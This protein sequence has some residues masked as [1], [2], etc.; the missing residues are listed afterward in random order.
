MS[1]EPGPREPHT[2]LLIE[3]DPDHATLIRRYLN[4]NEDGPLH[5]EWVN[6]LQKGLARLGQGGVE[7]VLL[8]LGLP[9]TTPQGALQDTL[10]RASHVPV[11]V[12]TARNSWD[13]TVDA[14]A[15]KL[16]AQD[17]LVKSQLNSEML[18]RSI[19][20]AVERK[21][22]EEQ[23]RRLNETL[24][25]RIA[26]RSAMAE[27]RANQLRAL[28]S[29]LILTEQRQRRRIAAELHDY[30]AQLL[31]VCRMKLTLLQDMVDEGQPAAALAD[32]Q[33]MVENS[34]RY[35]RTLV[36]E[37]SP[38]V[39]YEAGLDAALQWLAGQMEKN[40]LKVTFT[41][42]GELDRLPEDH[43]VLLFQSVRELLFNVIKHARVSDAEL[44]M[45]VLPSHELELEVRD[46]GVGCDL[47]AAKQDT[48]TPRFGI[49]SI[50]ERLAAIGGQFEFT[51]V[52]GE[53]TC[54]RITIPIAPAEP[55][56]PAPAGAANRA[57]GTAKSSS[58]TS[59]SVIRVLLADDHALV[60]QGLSS[61]LADYGDVQVI[62]E[63][64]NGEEAVEMA[65]LLQ[66]D[67]V[68]MDINMPK[69]NGIEATRRIK[70][71]M[72]EITVLALSVLDDKEMAAQ[73]RRAGAEAYLTKDGAADELYETIRRLH[74]TKS[75][76][77]KASYART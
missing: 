64:G 3:D 55:A 13:G 50:Q 14:D 10:A 62:G 21:R 8:D 17:Y 32:A 72:P 44:V 77:S 51:S 48:Q 63:A 73:M 42:N 69:V 70:S 56:E 22:T 41:Q 7:V 47:D 24:E 25:Q 54:A 31:V 23:L 67:T 66:P 39:L 68:V 74:H 65:R 61:L 9:D 34:L 26:E 53:G 5:V 11:I 16:G 57:G 59:R 60:R 6:T 27:F 1:N 40:G 76:T 46:D 38:T 4:G 52:P 29:E 20:Y 2:V 15:V 36:A 19:R 75:T 30:L 12:L 49:F 35:T 28:A 37:L 18:L 43:S 71:E 33:E 45:N 58:A